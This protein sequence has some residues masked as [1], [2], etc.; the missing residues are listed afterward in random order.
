VYWTNTWFDPPLEAYASTVL[1]TDVDVD[2]LTHFMDS[3]AVQRVAHGMENKW[4]VGYHSDMGEYVGNSV[5]TSAL[6][7]WVP[8]YD[9]YI[10]TLLAGEWPADAYW[11]SISDGIVDV[12]MFSPILEHAVV[13]TV[14][15]ERAQ[16]IA[17]TRQVFC[18]P[19]AVQWM[20]TQDPSSTR[21]LT[22]AELLSMSSLSTTIVDLGDIAIPLTEIT[23]PDG[24]TITVQVGIGAGERVSAA[25]VCARVLL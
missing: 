8:L 25:V 13:D 1:L 24:L 14:L 10:R 11:G 15:E 6:W 3:F 23:L 17:G 9:H 19:D 20:E 21:C 12:G 2:V 4:S 18:G 22:D 7:N 16:L 5:L